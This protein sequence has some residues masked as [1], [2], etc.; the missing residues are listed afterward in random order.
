MVRGRHHDWGSTFH[1]RKGSCGDRRWQW[2]LAWTTT[3][4]LL[5]CSSWHARNRR[6]RSWLH[7]LLLLRCFRDLRFL[8]STTFLVFAVAIFTIAVFVIATGVGVFPF[9]LILFLSAELLAPFSL[10]FL[11]QSWTSDETANEGL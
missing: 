6:W 11:E 10:P 3:L 9:D 1:R 5:G 4:S 2:H 8:A 7:W